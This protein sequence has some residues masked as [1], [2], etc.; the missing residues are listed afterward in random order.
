MSSRF[1]SLLVL[2]ALLAS[3]LTAAPRAEAQVV[4][5]VV[6]SEIHYHPQAVGTSYP[7]FDES[8]DTEFIELLNLESNAVDLSDWCLDAAVEF[9]FDAGTSL[10]A[11]NTIVI[12][13][14]AAAFDDAYGFM[15]S[16]V[17]SGKLSNGGERVRLLTDDNQ[18]VVDLTWQ[19][20]D[21]WPVTP[22]GNGP[23][24]ELRSATGDIASPANWRAST[25]T[26]GN[27]G[28]APSLISAAPPLVTSHT[29]AELVSA[30]QSIPVT[31][32]AVNTQSMR[33]VYNVDYGSNQTIDMT[34]TA[35]QWQASLPS[36]STGG[37]LQF[38][39]EATG[40]G[41]TTTSPRADDVVSWWAVG[42]ASPQPNNAP[43][44]DLFFSPQAWQDI[45]DR[46]CGCTGAVAYEGRIW[47]DVAMRRA[48]FTSINQAKA[49]LRLDFP[50]G[51]PFEASFLD[52]PVD[53]LTLDAGFPNYELL[54]EKLSWDVMDA[55]GYPAIR[56]QHVRVHQRGSFHGLY[57]LREEQDGNWRARHDLDR[58]AFYKVESW[59]PNS[60]G[61]DGLFTKKEGLDEPDTDVIALGQC[62]QQ[63]GAALRTC[64]NDTTDVPN[65][66][67]EFASLIIVWQTDQREFNYFL[68]RDNT[69]NGLW[70]M[71][72]DDLD[73]SWGAH[74]GN[75]GLIN[76]DTSSG[77]VY[78][79]CVG[80]D[81]TPANEICKAFMSV[82]EFKEMYLRR[83]R[84]LTDEIL[85]DPVWQQ[86]IA[87][88]AAFIS[89]DWTDDDNKW[90]R[91]SYSFNQMVTALD[92]FVDDYT[93][94]LR[95]GG[96]EGNIPA[97]QSSAPTVSI[98]GYRSDPG[99]GLGYVLITNPSGS[100]SVDLS[101][102]TFDGR[103]AI[104]G[105]LVVLPGA[106]VAVSTNDQLFRSMNP[107]FTGVRAEVYDTLAGQMQLR[108][109]DGS[110]AT[111]V[112]QSVA[113]PLI[114]TEWN[115]VSSTNVIAG[116]D[117]TLGSIPGNGGDW[118]ELAVIE[119][120]LD[121]RGWRLVL[122]DADGPSQAARDSFIFADEP[123]LAELEAGTIITVSESFADDVE[124]LPAFGDWHINFQAN[125]ADQGAFF[126][127]ASQSNFDT[128]RHNWQL[129]I[130]DA[131]DNLMF[132]PAGEGIG[133][134]SGVNSSEVGEL[135]VDPSADVNPLTDYGDGNAST[136]GLPN[137][138]AGVP[139]DFSALRYPYTYMDVDCT[140]TV[141]V[142]DALKIAQ[143]A[144]GNRQASTRCPLTDPATQMY[145]GAADVNRNG[146]VSVA[147]AL[148]VSQCTVGLPNIACPADG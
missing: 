124:F 102:W 125:S 95:A 12:A 79:R 146:G 22:D 34:E 84:T 73:R 72:P 111:T 114:L 59:D 128:N 129:S 23:S 108:R 120:G 30:G 46:E 40:P 104:P 5:N 1:R 44:V 50:D 76:P 97:A 99:D 58:G 70:R 89:D 98:T 106:T 41:G 32:T 13:D 134:A 92:G 4:P 110:A 137:T 49:H 75:S 101:G 28:S 116:G 90:N 105:G 10:A 18:V 81:P 113:A 37:L 47:T 133:S 33:L 3:A 8:E 14:D 86:Q 61:F 15:P 112:G 38:R 83:I 56:S 6:I 139:Q 107:A 77:K 27:P 21:P 126:T 141:S 119:D 103:A 118:F 24:L 48:G 123:L 69:Q 53:E 42:V 82:P 62:V 51:H 67:N 144:V 45:D 121:I 43:V 136:F 143:Y 19:T 131:N 25:S 109:R 57:L 135:E 140:G 39:F 80:T 52:G 138:T 78:R 9:C 142:S 36:L 16:G 94:H 65:M 88:M 26:N 64:L 7:D 54:R 11:S 145:V 132:G 91:T 87:S 29:A 71:L 74:T 130:F 20:S 117:A 122:S 17:Y 96:H 100:E 2:V 31:A 55:I 127:A 68:H 148:F 35:G 147:D 63:T 60:F 115:A 93:A 85:D 66:I